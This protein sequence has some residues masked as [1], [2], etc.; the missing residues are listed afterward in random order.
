MSS[1]ELSVAGDRLLFCHEDAG[2]EKTPEQTWSI[3]ARLAWPLLLH[4]VRRIASG[5][6]HLLAALLPSFLWECRTDTRDY[7]EAALAKESTNYLDGLRGVAAL[8]VFNFHFAHGTYV[9]TMDRVYRSPPTQRNNHI[10]Q[11]PVIRLFYTAEASVAIFFVLSGYT[12]SRRT[13]AAI[14]SGDL[15]KANVGVS[16]LALRRGIRLFGPAMI[17]SLL[18]YLTQRAGWMLAKGLPKD[19]VGDFWSD[20]RM[21]LAY[22]GT[23]LDIW[24]WEIDLDAGEWWFNPHVWTVPVEFRCSMVVFYW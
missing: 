22:L 23:L 9:P 13:I 17:A 7:N 6:S 24:T 5:T 8:A 10:I 15:E 14:L 19:Y 20:S 16:S 2:N 21:Y 11:L 1:D 3:R 18:V 4:A 12:L